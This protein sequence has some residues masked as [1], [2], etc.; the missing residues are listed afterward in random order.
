MKIT[1]KQ[2]SNHNSRKNLDTNNNNNDLGTS[3]TSLKISVASQASNYGTL[4]RSVK[5][6]S[7]KRILTKLNGQVVG[8]QSHNFNPSPESEYK[9]LHI[10]IDKRNHKRVTSK[11]EE[12]YDETFLLKN[13]QIKRVIRIYDE[14]QMNNRS[15]SQNN[16]VISVD[17]EKNNKD[18]DAFSSTNNN[19]KKVH[20]LKN[21]KLLSKDKLFSKKEKII[22]SQ[23]YEP[24]FNISRIMMLSPKE[25]CKIVKNK[26]VDKPNNRF[27][28]NHKNL[29]ISREHRTIIHNPSLK[30]DFVNSK[31]NTNRSCEKPRIISTNEAIDPSNLTLKLDKLKKTLQ[32]KQKSQQLNSIIDNDGLTEFTNREKY[33]KSIINEVM[34]N[35]N[36]PYSIRV[37]RGQDKVRFFL[38]I[39]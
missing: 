39:Y 4:P 30:S 21:Q 8:Y 11:K 36:C 37:D 13:P 10:P 33:N 32:G 2:Q 9:K 34:F 1:K 35:G 29:P 17:K 23:I 22:I 15:K 27:S 19:F 26:S 6:N 3:D 18:K 31:N 20:D 38:L 12:N 24:K 14:N 7:N 28:T 5:N 16:S 25:S